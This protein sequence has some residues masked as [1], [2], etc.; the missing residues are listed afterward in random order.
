MV[1]SSNNRELQTPILSGVNYNFLRIK[2]KIILVSQ[3]LWGLIE[4]DYAELESIETL[5]EARKKD[6]KNNIKRDAKASFKVLSRM[7]FFIKYQMKPLP[8][9]LGRCLTKCIEALIR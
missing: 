6:L 9:L 4:D 5:M 2:I 1:N 3:E 8:N 7:I